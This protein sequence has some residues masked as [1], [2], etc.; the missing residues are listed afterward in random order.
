VQITER[1]KHAMEGYFSWLQNAMSASPWSNV[2][3]N[4]KF[5]SYATDNV[6]A[7][8]GL[9]QKLSHAKNL[10]DV[11]KIQAEFMSKQLDSFN[12]Q[13]KAIVEICTKAATGRGEALYL[14]PTSFACDMVTTL[15]WEAT[16]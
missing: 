5:M 6:T 2:D 13:T 14:N 12:E 16:Q 7:A 9:V 10:E 3:S 4:K 1:T 8:V 11:V 15:A